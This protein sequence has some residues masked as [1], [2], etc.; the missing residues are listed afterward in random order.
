MAGLF[1]PE[2]LEHRQ[3][4]WIGQ[5]RAVRPLSLTLLTLLIVSSAAAI[6]VFLVFGEYTK[7]ARVPGVLLPE[8][9]LV[10]L[11]PL[12]A[13]TVVERHVQEGQSVRKGDVLFVLSPDVAI[14]GGEAQAAIRSSLA[15]Q[16]R[17]LR[18]TA[19]QQGR[20]A[21]ADLAEIDE[22]LTGMRRELERRDA[23]LEL[24]RKR[25]VLAQ[26]ELARY[27]ALKAQNFFSQA[28]VD[29]K[30]GEALA[31]QTELAQLELDRET[32]RREILSLEKQRVTLPLRQAQDRAAT[33]REL[34]LVV[35]QQAAA[36][37][38]NRHLVLAPQ[39]GV[40]TAV[41]ADVG[42]TATPGRALTT[43]M[44]AGSVLRAYLFAPSRAIGFVNE[45]QPVLLRY[46]AYPY[47]K[48]GHYMGRVVAVSHTPLQGREMSALP[49][50]REFLQE[51]RSVEE[52][53]PLYRITVELDTQTVHTYGRER[54]LTPGMQLDA[55]VMLDRRRLI[56]WIF[57]PVISITGRV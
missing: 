4:A 42:Q 3:Q 49:V 48:F 51:G 40:V 15:E 27:E 54:P 29:S 24:K 41:T 16:L 56:E 13:S 11:E 35:Q 20:T 39:D 44:P 21:Q 38:R 53:E 23:L 26:Q 10:R 47:Q 30:A 2:V 50:G 31:V 9:S 25:L 52:E 6:T 34:Q 43:L 18:E 45:Q 17:S 12:E 28:Q 55:D 1:R 14:R 32:H 57:E 19:E 33:E 5:I 7:K 22:R 37:S 8:K 46:R 36:E